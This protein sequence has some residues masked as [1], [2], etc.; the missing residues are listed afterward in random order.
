MP[1]EV[2]ATS[3][4]S[5]GPYKVCHFCKKEGHVL[6]RCRKYLNAQKDAQTDT[7]LAGAT[8]IDDSVVRVAATC[9][10]P[11]DLWLLDSGASPHMTSEVNRLLQP[12]E[13]NPVKVEAAG[14]VLWARRQGTGVVDDGK[15]GA[16]HIE[17]NLL[18]DGLR[19]NLSSTSQLTRCGRHII[20]TAHNIILHNTSSPLLEG[21]ESHSVYVLKNIIPPCAIA[22]PLISTSVLT[23]QRFTTYSSTCRIDALP[24]L[25][26]SCLLSSL[27]ALTHIYL[28]AFMRRTV[29]AVH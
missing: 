11:L 15:G 28:A 3:Q 22:L 2:P 6:R 29:M 8:A 19:M 20:E 9:R 24:T 16:L 21:K 10:H 26:L 4:F 12:Q 14:K 1:S 5:I 7:K 13:I 23:I 18:L 25:G 17:R 27:H